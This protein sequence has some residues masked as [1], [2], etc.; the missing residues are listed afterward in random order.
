MSLGS[1]STGGKDRNGR[2]QWI[3]V[4]MWP[5]PMVLVHN[6]FFQE[7]VHVLNA[8]IPHLPWFLSSKVLPKMLPPSLSSPCRSLPFLLALGHCSQVKNIF[9]PWFG[10][11]GTHVYGFKCL[12]QNH[13][14]IIWNTYLNSS[15]FSEKTPLSHFHPIFSVLQSTIKL[16]LI[17]SELSFGL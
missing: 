10:P 13:I 17:F 3:L 14:N 9:I 6:A 4:E 5:R 15:V 11:G 1:C 12:Y 16:F 2:E 7:I 8:Q